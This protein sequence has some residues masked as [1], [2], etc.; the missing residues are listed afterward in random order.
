[1]LVFAHGFDDVHRVIEAFYPLLKSTKYPLVLFELGAKPLKIGLKPIES[2][3]S[4]L[5]LRHYQTPFITRESATPSSY[6]H[7]SN[8][9]GTFCQYLVKNAIYRL[10][11]II[12]FIAITPVTPNAFTVILFCV[13]KGFI[14]TPE[15]PYCFVGANDS[16][17]TSVSLI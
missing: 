12:S 6:Y 9:S 1:M 3:L 5:N 7:Y 2:F 11:I 17:L 13:S 14:N 10:K 16:F 8:L 4:H 15:N